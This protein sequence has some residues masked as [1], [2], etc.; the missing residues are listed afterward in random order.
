[1][2]PLTLF[3]ACTTE[4]VVPRPSIQLT[5][6]DVGVKDIWLDAMVSGSMGSQTL[7]LLRDGATVLSVGLTSSDTTIISDGLLPD[8]TYSLQVILS[9]G[10][11]SAF[12][13]AIRVTTLD[14][15]NHGVTWQID[16]LGE[17]S[18]SILR[19][20]AILN[21]TLAYAVGEVY[22]KDS[23]GNWDPHAY[24][25][26]RWNGISWTPMRIQFYTI[27]GQPART[28]YSASSIL[29]FDPNDI[30][31]A[32]DG[33]QVARWDGSAQTS[34][35][36][37]PMP[38]AIQ[39]LWGESP[40]SVYAV[41]TG[42][43]IVHY[44]GSTWMEIP[45]GTSLPIWD[46]WGASDPATGDQTVLC[47]ASDVFQG[48]GR[49]LLRIDGM[50]VTALSDSGLATTLSGIW[51]APDKYY[52]LVGAGI[53]WKRGISAAAW[54][55]YEPGEVTSY[56]SSGIRGLGLNDIFVVGSFME[57]VHFNG[58]TWHNY[59][60][61]MPTSSGVTG[62]LAVT[63]NLVISVGLTGQKAIALVGRR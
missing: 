23:L 56:Y 17:G 40:S 53:H 27:C 18:G 49:K 7:S 22:F 10:R 45:S 3:T 48:T 15:T 33:D 31:V 63:E 14:T 46:I 54:N 34:T 47:I 4:M 60:D 5:V 42:G 50:A 52:Y 16:T 36:C 6:R 55:V 51:F 25:L 57:V 19:D 21:D 29:A 11:N 59:N 2:V 28:P 58:E 32:M 41:G 8:H 30:W 61:V 62:G 1:M 24:N 9:E 35:M 12:P 39:K 26:V 37:L 44:D 13:E 20:V 43:H 38:F